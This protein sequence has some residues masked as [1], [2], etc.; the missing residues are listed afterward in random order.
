MM[1][2]G[3]YTILLDGQLLHFTHW[4]DLPAEFDAM[5]KFMPDIPPGPHTHEQHEAIERLPQIFREFMLRER[6]HASHHP[7]R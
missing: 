6:K 2:K 1:G 5:I 4:D 7:S 3:E